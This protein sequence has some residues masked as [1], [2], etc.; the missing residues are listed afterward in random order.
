MEEKSVGRSFLILSMA[1]ILVK[2]MSAAYNPL[3]RSIIGTEGIGIYNASYNYFI[4]I[5]AIT[6]LGAQPAVAKVVSELRALGYDEDA[7]RVM[8]VA[9]KYLAIIG[10]LVTVIFMILIGPI[11]SITQ[12]DKV[13]LSLMFLAP[14]VFFSCILATYRGYF[15]GIEEM[16][17]LAISQV[18]EQLVNVFFSLIFAFLFIQ[19]SVEWGSAGGTVGT[20]IGAIVALIFILVIYDRNRYEE[21]AEEQNKSEKHIS[22]KKI[23]KKLIKYG[24]PIILVAA[25]QNSSGMID[26]INVKARLLTAGFAENRAN[27]LFGIL[28]CYN[29]LLYVPLSIVTALSSAIFPKIIQA[30]TTKRKKE[31]KSH[32]S[33]SFKLTYLVTIPAAVGLSMLSREVYIMLYN[34]DEGYQ[35]LMYGSIV[36]IFMSIST[37]QNTILQ[38]I[39]KLYLVLSTAFLSI[40]IKFII[41]YFL[42]G[43]KDINILG[44]VFASLFAFLVPVII[45]QKRLRKIFKMKIPIIRLGIIPFISSCVMALSIYLCRIPIN[46]MMNIIEGGRIATSLVALILIAIGGCV[47]LVAMIL[48][49]GI[50]K[51]DL[52][53]I[54]PKLFTLLPRFLRKNM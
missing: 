15:Q 47:Y 31:L 19:I 1:G 10:A 21:K 24:V 48:L 3:L 11:A 18:I 39:N 22:D 12:W 44:A 9:R 54:S 26:T 28:G 2:I 17:T 43:I 49:G 5:L 13:T 4:F 8:K 38:G 20:T 16:K 33:Y 45:N 32:I 41:N 51:R 46:R 42:V 23:L 53:M 29:T 7:L 40:I 6:S 14:T 52:D 30:F 27:E 37:I 25:L 50:K 36:L 35:L 34:S